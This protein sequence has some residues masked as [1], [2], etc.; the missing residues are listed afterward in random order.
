MR[1][2]VRMKL[3]ATS[4]QVASNLGTLGDGSFGM[5]C[6]TDSAKANAG[7]LVLNPRNLT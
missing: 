2:M 3:A 5:Y 4:W 6:R 1:F 7:V